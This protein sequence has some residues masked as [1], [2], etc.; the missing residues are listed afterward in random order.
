MEQDPAYRQYVEKYGEDNAKYIWETMHGTAI[1]HEK[2][3][4]IEIP[5]TSNPEYAELCRKHAEE[6]G[7]A[8]VPLEGSLEILRNLVFGNWNSEDFLVLQPGSRSKGLYDWEEIMG[9]E[10]I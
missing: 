7:M 6:S 9:S 4:Y 3:V 5:E 8:F 2:L 10:V 1:K